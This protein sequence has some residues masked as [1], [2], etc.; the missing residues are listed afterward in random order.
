MRRELHATPGVSAE[1]GR[2]EFSVGEC[3]QC[4]K[5]LW[6]KMSLWMPGFHC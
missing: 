6:G 1:S 4:E 5:R 2:W 3:D